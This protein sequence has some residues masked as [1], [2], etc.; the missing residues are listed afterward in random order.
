MPLL[1]YLR[2]L[3][4]PRIVLWCYAIWYAVV[5][6]HYFDPSLML[7]LTSIGLSGIIGCALLLSTRAAL[8]SLRINGWGIFRLFLMP[9]CVSS[10]SALVKGRDFLLIFPPS[11]HENLLALGCIAAFC[12]FLALLRRGKKTG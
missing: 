8:G 4:A 5:F 9:F 2:Q 7:W 6:C 11:L 10:F 1:R 3:D 12:L